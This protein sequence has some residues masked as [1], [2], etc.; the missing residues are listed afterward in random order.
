MRQTVGILGT[1]IDILNTHAVLERIEQFIREKRFHQVATANTDFLIN[2]L[3]DPELSHIL[4]VADLVIPDGMPV[5]WASRLVNSPLQERVTGADIVPELASLASRKGYRIFMLGARPEVAQKAKARM[6]ADYPG[7]QIVG[8]LSPPNRPLIA[9][10]NDAILVEIAEAK[11]DILLVAFGN[12][13]QEKWIHLH[14][15]ALQEVP[16]CIGVGGTFDFLAGEISRAPGWMQKSGL[17]WVFRLAQ[18]PR[19]LWKRY[20]RDI[21]HFAGYLFRQWQGLRQRRANRSDLFAAETG[22]AIV[23][24]IIGDFNHSIIT[25]FQK[26]TEDAFNAGKNLILD[27]SSVTSLDGEACGTLINLPKR[28][29]YKNCDICLVSV[30]PNIEKALKSSQIN[31]TIYKI[32][33]SVAQAFST[34][35]DIGLCWSV[36]CSDRAAVIT[37]HGSSERLTASRLEGVC[38]H[39]LSTGRRISLD[40]RGVTYAD[41]SLLTVL[42]RL[43]EPGEQGG[44]ITLTPGSAVSGAILREKMVTVFTLLDAPK[45]TPEMRPYETLEVQEKAGTETITGREQIA[46]VRR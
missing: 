28:A 26:A 30:P 31:E 40:L 39:L 29:A 8:C 3:S 12:P 38:L 23:L 14:R 10:D 44:T 2:A 36:Q 33:P 25:R 35:K 20:V 19:R 9:M 1:P 43:N 42:Y 5:V 32:A 18:E 7:V 41:T 37:V 46:G 4:R 34:G 17:E 15:E 21:S 22:D 45:I 16:V 24:S 13:K 6:E 27:F 11:P